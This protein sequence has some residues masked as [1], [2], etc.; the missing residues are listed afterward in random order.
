[1]LENFWNRLGANAGT[2]LGIAAA[3]VGACAAII[4]IAVALA[5]L[6]G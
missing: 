1:M 6:F 4:I 2:L 3:V 5:Y